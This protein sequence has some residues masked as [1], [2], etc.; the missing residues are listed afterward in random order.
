M[1]LRTDPHLFPLIRE[2]ASRWE[3]AGL[4]PE[5]ERRFNLLA[6]LLVATFLFGWVYT[7]F[8][9]DREAFEPRAAPVA[10]ISSRVTQS[11]LAA[12]APP[13]PVFLVDRFAETFAEEFESFRGLSGELN[14]VIRAPGDSLALPELPD[15]VPSGV[16]L[17]FQPAEEDGSSGDTAGF[18]VESAASTPG[19][20]NVVLQ[21]RDA[22]RPVSGVSVINTV[23]LSERSG[24]RI[25]RYLVGSWPF[26][27]GGAPKPIYETPT[28]VIRVTAENRGLPVS[29]HFVLGDF[30]TKGQADVW[31]KYVVLSTRLLDKLELTLQELERS[32]HPVEDVFVVSGF[33]TPVYNESGGNTQGRGNLSRHMYG[34]AAD[35]AIDNNGDRRMDDLNGDGRVNV[36]DAR[37]VAEAA[38]RVEQKYPTLIGGIGIY[39]PTGAHAGMVHVD[40]R[41]YRARWGAW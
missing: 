16:A 15:T 22:I 19:I 31:P 20:W 2:P 37:I 28:G 10:R 7:I 30:L 17:A 23:P 40:A 33:R 26:E 29:E 39:A 12:G 6:S 4:T 3:R 32:G 36:A 34:D 24:G 25:G 13:E 35:I 21:M 8:F 27:K 14:V 11:P 18:E 1:E 5:Q 9:L 41:G 38:Q